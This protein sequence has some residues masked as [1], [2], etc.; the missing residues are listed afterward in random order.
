M[1]HTEQDVERV[2]EAIYELEKQVN[3]LEAALR[4]HEK[5]VHE[6]IR[7]YL[8]DLNSGQRYIRDEIEQLREWAY[9]RFEELTPDKPEPHLPKPEDRDPRIDGP[10]GVAYARYDSDDRVNGPDDFSAFADALEIHARVLLRE[11]LER[12][13]SY[14]LGEG[15]CREGRPAR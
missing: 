3:H 2:A 1:R 6:G 4:G 8:D 10:I 12:F 15:P 9:R 5:N 11:E 7:E 14:S 13:F